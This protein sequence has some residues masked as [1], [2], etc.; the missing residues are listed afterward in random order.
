MNR[1][2][3]AT[4]LTSITL[5]LT[6]CGG[7]SSKSSLDGSGSVSVDP[8]GSFSGQR[9]NAAIT[10]GDNGNYKAFLTSFLGTNNLQDV[11][12]RNTA[13][14]NANSSNGIRDFLTIS[15]AVK[16]LKATHTSNQRKAIPVSDTSACTNGG[17]ITGSGTLDDVTRVGNIVM[18]FNNCIEGTLTINGISE[19]IIRN[20]NFTYDV[21]DSYILKAQNLSVTSGDESYTSTAIYDVVE[22]YT[23]GT[24]VLLINAL[25]TANDIEIFYENLQLDTD[26]GGVLISGRIYTEEDGYVTITTDSRVLYNINATFPY[27]GGPI[28][29]AGENSNIR[30]TPIANE[31]IQVEL[32]LDGDGVYEELLIIGADGN[33]VGNTDG[34]VINSDT[35]SF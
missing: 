18:T 5:S 19:V 7:G 26:S 11:A 27:T 34:D 24:A 30:I 25:N 35:V 28:T 20:Y 15:S 12:L 6:A 1:K 16:K 32:D 13:A 23:A 9:S 14:S 8:S 33:I 21:P 22:D 17:S 2:L 31:T 10:G 3:L 4:L 29:L